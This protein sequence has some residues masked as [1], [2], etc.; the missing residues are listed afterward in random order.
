LNALAQGSAQRLLLMKNDGELAWHFAMMDK[1][2]GYGL[3]WLN[4]DKT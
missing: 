2:R 1:M 4:S 3:L